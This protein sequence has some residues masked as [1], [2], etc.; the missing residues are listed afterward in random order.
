MAPVIKSYIY[1]AV[2]IEK[3]G[4]KVPLKKT[5]D[6]LIPEEFQDQLDK[7]KGLKDAFGS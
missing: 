6:Y 3:A 5:K 7:M 4:L 2:E 1:E